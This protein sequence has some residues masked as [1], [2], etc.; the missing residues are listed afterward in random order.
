[1]TDW[2][3]M[4]LILALVA[5]FGFLQSRAL[6]QAQTTPQR[7]AALVPSVGLLIAVLIIVIGVA[8]DPTA[9]NLWPLELLLWIGGGLLYFAGLTLFRKFIGPKGSQA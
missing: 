1:M 6:K 9:H 4:G 7:I 2:I 8:S 5:G 3:L